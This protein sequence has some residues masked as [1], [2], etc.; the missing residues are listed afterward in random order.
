MADRFARLTHM[1]LL[2]PLRTCT[3]THSLNHPRLSCYT[4]LQHLRQGDSSLQETVTLFLS[5]ILRKVLFQLMRSLCPSELKLGSHFFFPVSCKQFKS[6]G[7]RGGDNPNKCFEMENLIISP[8]TSFVCPFI[9]A[10]L[11]CRGADVQPNMKARC[12]CP[13]GDGSPSSHC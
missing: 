6:E 3:N 12:L 11:E 8:P 7:G 1:H 4:G 5:S 10:K 9:A 13:Y 2:S